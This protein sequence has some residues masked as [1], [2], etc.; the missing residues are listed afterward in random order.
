MKFVNTLMDMAAADTDVLRSLD[1]N[2]D[3][4]SIPRNVDFFLRT[5]SKEKAELIVSFIHDYS[6]GSAEVTGEEDTDVLWVISMPVTQSVILCVSGFVASIC[7]IYEIE[8]D[9]WGCE[10]QKG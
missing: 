3:D 4:F 10:S 6:Y 1:A 8:Y 2:G 9:G 5:P 7:H